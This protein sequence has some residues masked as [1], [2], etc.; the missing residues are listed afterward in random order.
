MITIL[1]CNF[2]TLIIFIHLHNK[3][4]NIPEPTFKADPSHRVKVIG[5]HFY[6]LATKPMRE[7]KVKNE[8]A[9]RMKKYWTYMINQQKRQPSENIEDVK[10][11]AKAPLKHLFG[12]HEN[13]DECWCLAKTAEKQGK[14]YI[15]KD[16]PYLDME[17]DKEVYEDLKKVCDRFSTDERLHEIMHDGD[18]Q[19]NECLNM[20]LAHIAPK[21]TNYSHS[22][23][24]TNRVAINAGQQ[25]GPRCSYWTKVYDNVGV[26]CCTNFIKHMKK[27]DDRREKTRERKKT[28]DYK[29]KRKH[30]TNAKLLSQIKEEQ[31]IAQDN[32]G[33]YGSGAAIAASGNSTRERNVRQ[34]RS[35]KCGS[36][37]HQ[38]TSH[39]NC[40]LNKRN[41]QQQQPLEL[42][43]E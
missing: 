12:N 40:P 26:D 4:D 16:G 7:S 17:K 37:S 33:T 23:S 39:Q 21:T 13:C 43:T 19:K 5:K 6:A 9:K 1:L 10:K 18:T 22:S 30:K 27:I 2:S 38:R 25:N 14:V 11:A 3:Q 29:R 28:I 32:L 15:S 20:T 24:L 8:H 41:R 34:K 36:D 42:G 31:I 35:C